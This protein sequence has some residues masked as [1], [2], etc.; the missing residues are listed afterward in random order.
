V[1]QDLHELE[2]WALA[3]IA[4]LTPA[5]R[6]TLAREIAN[7]LR[8]SQQQRIAAQLNPDGTPYVPRK[9]QLRKKAGRIRRTMFAKL[10][11]ARFLKM[12]SRSDAA[13]VGF[14]VQVA[15]IARVHQQGLRDRVQ[16]IGPYCHYPARQLLGLAK[17]DREAVETLL[18]E[19][20]QRVG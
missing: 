2:A 7:T 16:P 4:R 18:L 5:A 13:I 1:S 14:G 8:A 20:V 19:H 11:T 6:R 3:L 12:D 9:P 17:A 15:R 10:R